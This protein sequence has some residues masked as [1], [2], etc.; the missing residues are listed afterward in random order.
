[1]EPETVTTIAAGVVSGLV[2]AFAGVKFAIRSWFNKMEKRAEQVEDHE[3]RLTA[4]EEVMRDFREELRA[5]A[6]REE[7]SLEAI[8]SKQI[9]VAK[10]VAYI[11]GYI[12]AIHN[13]GEGS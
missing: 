1:M 8:V 5:H 11:R 12:D 9:E 4:G 13:K 7:S 2:T 10:D 6:K 3:R